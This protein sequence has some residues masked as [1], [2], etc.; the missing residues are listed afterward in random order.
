MREIS[1]PKRELVHIISYINKYLFHLES[2][3][4][5]RFS[6]GF[7]LLLQGLEISS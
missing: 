7:Y 5:P 3:S 2:G 4:F 1:L 6:R